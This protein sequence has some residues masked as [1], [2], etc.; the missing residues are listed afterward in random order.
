MTNEQLT[1]Y[2]I[3]WLGLPLITGAI[4][5]AKGRS[6]L[7]WYLWGLLAWIIATPIILFIG[8][9]SPDEEVERGLKRRC[10]DCAE[11]VRLAAKVCPH[12]GAALPAVPEGHGIY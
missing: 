10:Q 7:H 9:M 2:L 8:R 12:C 6:F 11:P 1:Q 5:Q 4:A 3:V